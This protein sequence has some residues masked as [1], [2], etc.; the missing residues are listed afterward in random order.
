MVVNS[1]VNFHGDSD[2][3]ESACNVGDPGLVP[4]VTVKHIYYTYIF[5]HSQMEKKSKRNIIFTLEELS[6]KFA[7]KF[8]KIIAI[9]S[10]E[11]DNV[12]R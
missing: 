1:K 9:K 8:N 4:W 5:I 7:Q 3:K 6:I 11:L 2:D 10:N 12:G